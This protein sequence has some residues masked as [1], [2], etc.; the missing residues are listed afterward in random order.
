MDITLAAISL[1]A[2]TFRDTKLST[3]RFPWAEGAERIAIKENRAVAIF[4]D[5]TI[6]IGWEDTY[7]PYLILSE[8]SSS[9]ANPF[10]IEDMVTMLSNRAFTEEEPS[11]EGGITQELN[12]PKIYASYQPRYDLYVDRS[13]IYLNDKTDVQIGEPLI[14]FYV[15]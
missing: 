2:L 8:G 6:K 11:K 15:D 1:S 10:T 13:G 9:A 5:K 3:I 14:R 7:D 4:E 12:G